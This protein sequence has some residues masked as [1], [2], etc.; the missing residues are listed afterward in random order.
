MELYFQ[1]SHTNEPYSSLLLR[2]TNLYQEGVFFTVTHWEHDTQTACI[3]TGGGCLPAFNNFCL[4][5][6][7]GFWQIYLK[8]AVQISLKTRIWLNELRVQETGRPFGGRY[9]S[10]CVKQIFL[11]LRVM[12]RVDQTRK[13]SFPQAVSEIQ[14]KASRVMEEHQPVSVHAQIQGLQSQLSSEEERFTSWVDV[15][16]HFL[17]F[18]DTGLEC[19]SLPPDGDPHN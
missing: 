6:E 10:L 5:K 7:L 15:Y 16:Q 2:E 12:A 3:S 1:L 17:G 4:I 8:Y 18:S 19:F 13:E 9:G 11:V 14:P